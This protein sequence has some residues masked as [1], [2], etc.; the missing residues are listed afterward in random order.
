M[1]QDIPSPE[2]LLSESLAL[3]KTASQRALKLITLSCPQ[4]GVF[5]Q[6]TRKWQRFCSDRC[7]KLAFKLSKTVTQSED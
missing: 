7:R 4:C 6:P 2:D 5:F 3:E 1:S